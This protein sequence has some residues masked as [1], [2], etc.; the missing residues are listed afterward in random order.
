MNIIKLDVEQHIQFS[1][2][3]PSANPRATIQITNTNPEQ[4]AAFKFR[5][6]APKLFVVKPIHGIV[7]PSR[8]VAID[9]QLNVEN[10]QNLKEFTKSKIMVMATSTELQ[11]SEGFKLQ[12][13][14][15]DR[16]KIKDPNVIQQ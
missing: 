9:I 12:K 11:S 6:T 5:T 3:D 15:E 7:Q 14:W 8:T 16:G 10:I 2:P 1:R 13:F 4:N